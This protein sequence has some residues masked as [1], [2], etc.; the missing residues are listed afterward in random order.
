MSFGRCLNVHE[1][2]VVGEIPAVEAWPKAHGLEL[3][4]QCEHIEDG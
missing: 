3:T 4:L 1:E 2:P